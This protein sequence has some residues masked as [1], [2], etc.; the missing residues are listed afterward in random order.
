MKYVVYVMAAVSF[1]VAFSN[2]ALVTVNATKFDF[3][4]ATAEEQQDWMA[5]KAVSLKRAAKLGLPSGR[6][7]TA[8][9]FY[10]DDVQSRPRYREMEMIIRV[11]VPYGA[12]V[13]KAPREK[14]AETL[15]NVSKATGLLEQNI[16]LFA[17]FRRE[18][19]GRLDRVAVSPDECRRILGA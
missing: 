7:P 11:K 2:T 6:G 4:A 18:N 12:Q 17:T 16:R 5:K 14:T 9:N 8:L 3:A 10:I 15:C 19:G 1:F 13:Q